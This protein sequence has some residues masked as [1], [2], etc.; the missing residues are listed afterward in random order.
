MAIIEAMSGKGVVDFSSG[1]IAG[2]LIAFMLP[3][4]LGNLFQQLYNA[5]DTLIVGNFLGPDALAAVSSSGSLIF[6]MV[7]FFN[8]M[9]VGAG[10]VIS[11]AYGAGDRER[12][13]RAI[14]S[15][16]AFGIL[17]GL[18]ITIF[19]VLFTP[20][21]LRWIST[22]ETLL[23]ISASYFRIYSAGIFFSVMYNVLMGIINAL[24]DSRHPLCYLIASS[25]INIVLDLLLV[26]VFGL[27]VGSAALATI[28]SQAVS[29]LLCLRRL[30]KG[31]GDVSVDMK[32]IRIDVHEL[33]SIIRFGLPSGMQNSIV[34]LANTVIQA[35]VNGFPSAAIAGFGVY[36]KIEG[37]VLLPITSFSLAF[38]TFI[39]QMAGAGDLR[40]A[41][42]GAWEG[43]AMNLVAAELVGVLLFISA[44]FLV[45]LFTSDGEV[46]AYGV[47][48]ARLEAFFYFLVAISHGS[49]GMLRG[50][51][52][53][54]VPMLV[55][56][57][58][59][60]VIRVIYVSVMLSFH[61][62]MMVIYSA[63]PL[64]WFVS[65]L[66]FLAY[67]SRSRWLK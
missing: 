20:S 12:L 18:A 57:L 31:V 38:T 64:T 37:F 11:R 56:L 53:A 66:I 40:R 32:D 14:S 54:F 10:V 34:G 41:R 35:S 9:A 67:L 39:A 5:A 8:G 13:Q 44:P 55:M 45:G 4:L 15:D 60:C 58:S 33:R 61:H 63:Y 19:A 1:S 26:G 30:M 36:A 49:A 21:I 48:Q 7:G 43:M 28:V 17:A 51:G 46:I 3:L 42:K 23:P 29:S 22:P 25:L 50:A 6:M 16:I 27:G 47:R 24:G 52:R 2:K 62:D 59:W 65:S